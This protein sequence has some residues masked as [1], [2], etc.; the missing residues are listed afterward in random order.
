ML[1]RK[2][3]CIGILFGLVG[4]PASAQTPSAPFSP[5]SVGECERYRAEYGQSLNALRTGY[6]DCSRAHGSDPISTWQPGFNSPGRS[7]VV[8]VPAPCVSASDEWNAA[9]SN[10]QSSVNQC[11]SAARANV[12]ARSAEMRG[13]ITQSVKRATIDPAVSDGKSAAKKLAIWAFDK[14]MLPGSKDVVDHFLR[15][16]GQI[17]KA[18]QILAFARRGSFGPQDI[19]SIIGAFNNG[20]HLSAE[21][22]RNA[23]RFTIDVNLGYMNQLSMAMHG[24]SRQPPP[25]AVVADGASFDSTMRSLLYADYN[26]TIGR[27]I[28]A[29][30]AIVDEVT[31]SFRNALAETDA[32]WRQWQ[33]DTVDAWADDGL[34]RP[35]E[36]NFG[37]WSS[38]GSDSSRTPSLKGSTCTGRGCAVR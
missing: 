14:Y 38:G 30:N 34:S 21:L 2:V 28:V 33:A 25:F 22:A 13:V 1:N 12:L 8:N 4:A 24:F 27:H 36:S 32:A 6:Q 26:R 17:N 15:T 31:Q 35:P 29:F 19:D 37:G 7:V 18:D 3:F 11:L 23:A 20:H 9:S 16:K 5:G 10:F